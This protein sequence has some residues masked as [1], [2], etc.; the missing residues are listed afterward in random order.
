MKWLDVTRQTVAAFKSATGIPNYWRRCEAPT[1]QLPDRYIVYFSVDDL[2]VSWADGQE[3]AHETRVQI[4]FY[5]RNKA[6]YLTVP[7]QI[8]QAFLAA[9]FTRNGENDLPYQEDTGHYG[10]YLDLNYYER[11]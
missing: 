2:G 5:F 4:S 3:T 7:D 9:G 6:D 8:R 10:W 1:D 11:R